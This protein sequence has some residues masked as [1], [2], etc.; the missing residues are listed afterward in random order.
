MGIR[1]E[2][3]SPA[4]T[5]TVHH[6]G[7]H[8]PGAEEGVSED[9]AVQI[10]NRGG[11]AV[12]TGSTAALLDLLDVIRARVLA[13]RSGPRAP[14]LADGT[15]LAV[16][17]QVAREVGFQVLAAIIAA[18]WA[19]AICWDNTSEQVDLGATGQD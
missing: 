17:E 1:L 2:W 19:D 12:I 18:A 14:A 8:L 5:V 3:L 15:L 11:G 13:A 6:R 7:A 16:P 4:A 9:L 10:D